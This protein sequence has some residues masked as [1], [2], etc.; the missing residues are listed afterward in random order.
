MKRRI[1]K[2]VLPL[3]AALF[4]IHLSTAQMYLNDGALMSTTEDA[5][6]SLRTFD[7]INDGSFNHAGNLIV[8][9]SIT[10]NDSITCATNGTNQITLSQNWINNATFSSGDGNVLFNG[11]NQNI[12]GTVSSSFHD[13]SLNGIAGNVKT[14]QLSLTVQNALDLTGAELALQT[15]QLDLAR[16]STPVSRTVGYISTDFPGKVVTNIDIAGAPTIDLP[17]GYSTNALDYRPV[18]LISPTQGEYEFALYGNNPSVDGLDEFSLQDSLCRVQNIYYYYMKTGVND[19]NYELTY[20]NNDLDYTKTANWLR[21]QWNKVSNSNI[22]SSSSIAGAQQANLTTFITLGKEQA[23]ANAGDDITMR[24]G[25]TVVFNGS[26]YKPSSAT[27]SWS[28]SID[29]SCS[30]C[31]TPTFT[32]GSQGKYVLTVDNGIGCSDSD[33]MELVYW[34]KKIYIENAFSPNNDRLNDKFMPVLLTNEELVSLKIYN[35]YGQ[36]IYSDKTGWDATFMGSDVQQ[37][38]Y[39]YIMVINQYLLYGK[40]D[41]Y[42]ARGEVSVFR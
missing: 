17:L 24:S 2:R 30:D 35:S 9:G 21:G 32:F 10:N 3:L 13:L 20:K 27:R 25:S 1:K 40:K 29:L 36:K 8:E 7:F 18:T 15:N 31:F 28:P 5:L 37:G 34:R 12:D 22:V 19:L 23:F 4:S 41:I 42:I 39:I 33:T 6:V 11:T 16:A 14:A 26:G 38:V